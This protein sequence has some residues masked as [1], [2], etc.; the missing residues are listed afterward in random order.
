MKARSKKG[1]YIMEASIVLPMIVFATITA[2][3][4]IMFFYSQ[5]TQRSIMHMALR[6]EA[7]A[8]AGNTSFDETVSWDGEI[9]AKNTAV[10]GEV[11]GKRYL[12]MEHSGL[13]EKRGAF[14]LE[15]H[16][17]A[18]DAAEYIRYCSLIK[19]IRYE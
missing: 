2:V 9:Y 19:G 15:G 4:V 18:V 11:Y 13:L 3:L 12:L 6:Q 14:R 16:C 1:S 10:G 5:M 17:C 7:G 8:V